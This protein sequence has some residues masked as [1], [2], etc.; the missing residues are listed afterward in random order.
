LIPENP[1][2]IG[3]WRTYYYENKNKFFYGMLLFLFYVQ[4]HAIVLTDQ[5]F[6]HP[7]RLGNL[8]AL[9]P[10]YLGIRSKNHKVHV[11]IAL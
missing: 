6:F 5:E 4:I 7:A 11:G 10:I 1:N 9:I 2:E 8:I 3:S